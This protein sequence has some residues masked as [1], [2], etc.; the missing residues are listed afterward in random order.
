M[1]HKDPN[2][3]SDDSVWYYRMSE[4]EESSQKKLYLKNYKREARRLLYET[5]VRHNFSLSDS[6]NICEESVHIKSMFCNQFIYCAL[7]CVLDH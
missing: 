2:Q 5:I 1:F 4:V 6:N 3:S 7:S